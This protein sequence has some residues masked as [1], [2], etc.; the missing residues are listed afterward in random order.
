[1]SPISDSSKYLIVNGRK[2][3]RTFLKIALLCIGVQDQGSGVTA[4]ALAGIMADFPNVPPSVIMMFTTIPSLCM[5]FVCPIYAKIQRHFRKRSILWFCAILYVVG[6]VSAAFMNDVYA[7]LLTRIIQGISIS[8]LV[9]MEADLLC[10]FFEGHERHTM[11]GLDNA[12][13]SIGGMM[14]QMLGGFLARFDWHY[15]FL[16]YLV[17]ILFFA[18]ALSYVPE[19]E[20]KAYPS[21]EDT[22]EASCEKDSP[23]QVD[24]SAM[25]DPPGKHFS[26][27]LITWGHIALHT[28][29][30]IFMFAVLTNTSSII[31]SEGISDEGG[32]GIALG[33]LSLGTILS[34]LFFGKVFRILQY[35]I[36]ILGYGLA[37]GGFAL[38]CWGKNLITMCL[39]CLLVGMAQGIDTSSI[40]AKCSGSIHPRWRS[41][42]LSLHFSLGSI[43]A[44]L[45]P[46][47][48]DLIYFLKGAA[49]VPGR[50]AMQISFV[51]ALLLTILAVLINI[52]EKTS[53]SKKVVG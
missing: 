9:P 2:I 53:S 24:F 13:M 43:G 10:D 42:A 7:I 34:G 50:A 27:P 16:A 18:V 48:Y 15:C 38:G 5:V 19:P 12:V 11:V 8:I 4:P 25:K 47:I 14:L 40:V 1:M 39:M 3:N 41:M 6:G 45:Q 22:S 35:N 31:V 28:L 37:L 21:N 36:L 26:M 51:G 49:S 20:K 17:S 44:F 33:I 32:A 52:A 29:F 46:W 30:F 23:L